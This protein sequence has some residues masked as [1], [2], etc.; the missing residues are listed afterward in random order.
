MENN[1]LSK[2]LFVT[3]FAAVFF[4]YG[5][6]NASEHNLTDLTNTET[7]IPAMKRVGLLFQMAQKQIDLAEQC[8]EDIF[9]AARG[10]YGFRE[11]TSATPEEKTFFAQILTAYHRQF[12]EK[13]P[14]K[15]ATAIGNVEPS[16]AEKVTKHLGLLSAGSEKLSALAKLEGEHDSEDSHDIFGIQLTVKALFSEVSNFEALL[17]S[18]FSEVEHEKEEPVVTSTSDDKAADVLSAPAESVTTVTPVSEALELKEPK[19]ETSSDPQSSNI[20][21]N[22]QQTSVSTGVV[23]EPD[24]KVLASEVVTEEEKPQGLSSPAQSRKRRNSLE[25]S[26]AQPVSIPA[27][28]DEKPKA[29]D[30]KEGEESGLTTKGTVDAITKAATPEPGVESIEA[31]AGDDD[32]KPK[33]E[34]KSADASTTSAATVKAPRKAFRVLSENTHKGFLRRLF[35]LPPKKGKGK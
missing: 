1:K 7:R 32:K 6:A 27:S 23:Q 26:Q 25:H 18:F 24:S 13:T 31:S 30:H 9:Q 16:V 35:H 29:D 4:F 14:F 19:P 3:L 15:D 2:S 11:K 33:A 21:V 22:Q 28:S 10:K 34:V 17:R 20:P 5:V 12:P 8:F